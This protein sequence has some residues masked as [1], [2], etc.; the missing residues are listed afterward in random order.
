VLELA[1]LNR[2]PLRTAESFPTTVNDPRPRG[3][4]APAR[5]SV[6]RVAV[7]LVLLFSLVVFGSAC[8]SGRGRSTDVAVIEP[9]VLATPEPAPPIV[10]PAAA[11]PTPPAVATPLELADS[12]FDAADY[13][14]ARAGYESHL[15]SIDAAVDADRVLYRLAILNLATNGG[16]QATAAGYALLRRLVKEHPSSPY[17]M[18]AELILGLS[19]RVDGLAT[20]VEKLEGQ[21]EALKR[22]DLERSQNRRSP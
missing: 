13:A 7:A 2:R 1:T 6:E 17:R 19:A 21:L 22:I 20:E 9:P 18:E 12:A 16:G 10:L 3:T 5:A 15:A 11:T 8:R 14:A 4:G